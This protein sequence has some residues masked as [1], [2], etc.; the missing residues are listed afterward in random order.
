MKC[1]I[2]HTWPSKG[3]ERLPCLSPLPFFHNLFVRPQ[4]KLH[5][6]HLE[7]TCSPQV[8]D[9]KP[10]CRLD[11]LYEVMRFIFWRAGAGVCATLGICLDCPYQKP[12]LFG[13]ANGNCQHLGSFYFEIPHQ[14][15]VKY[16]KG[17]LGVFF[18]EPKII[19][20]KLTVLF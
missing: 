4:Q 2:R 14:M 12:P 7:G 11:R 13:K 19:L 8:A 6:L 1:A 5:A 16:G 15:L 9:R 17:H 20:M 18:C 10:M 3:E